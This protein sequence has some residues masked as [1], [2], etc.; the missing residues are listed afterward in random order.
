MTL[1]FQDSSLD[2]IWKKV[3]RQKRLDLDDARALHASPDALGIG[4]MAKRVKERRWGK[5]AFYVLNQKL[6]PTNVCVLSCKFCDFAV[7]RNQPNA[8]EMTI[9]EMVQKCSGD[10]SEIHISGGMPPEW[11]LENY[12]EIVRSLRQA[13]PRVGIKAFTAVEIEWAARISKHSVESVLIRLKE[14]G[15]TALPGGGAEVFSERVRQELFPF[16]IGAPEWLD[17]HRT[18]H[19][20]GIPTNATLL[21][22]HI[23]TP[24]ECWR[25]LELLRE[26]QDESL[27][28][29]HSSESAHATLPAR[30]PRRVEGG[31]P[32]SST[33][34]DPRIRGGDGSSA[35]GFMSF[36]PLAF[37]PGTTG[38]AVQPPTV[39]QDLKLL[40]ISR[41]YL[42]NVPHIKAYWVTLGEETASLGLHWGADD[43]DGTIGGEKIM[44][45][46]GAL[47]PSGLVRERLQ[48]LIR[49]AGCEP[50]ERDTLYNPVASANEALLI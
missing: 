18:A 38:L 29:R 1:P 39:I 25:H 9:G 41:L 10:I 28:R 47:S 50:V 21:Y 36:I 4:W 34:L 23:E 8:Y 19:R 26:L 44:H 14:A 37:Q 6:E 42:D 11:T 49:E 30:P 15:L 32:V 45:A 2:P 24:E 12:I 48:Q 43:V 7:K 17:V 20:L 31:N 5:R 27:I 13:Y 16:K 3:E 22:G 46:A 33:P 40:A 35:A